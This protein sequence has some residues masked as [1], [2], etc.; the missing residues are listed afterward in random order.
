MF[1][2]N[3]KRRMYTSMNENFP[4][5]SKTKTFFQFALD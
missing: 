2:R 1:D 3:F 5:A 4:K